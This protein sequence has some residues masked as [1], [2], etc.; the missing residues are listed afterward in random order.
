MVI[1]AAPVEISNT[2]ARKMACFAA[3][4]AGGDGGGLNAAEDEFAERLKRNAA[5]LE[6][7]EFV[8][9]QSGRL[10]YRDE[11]VKCRRG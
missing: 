7:G 2:T 5:P 11:L 4:R 10:G 3:R 8:K 6:D 1:N 9:G